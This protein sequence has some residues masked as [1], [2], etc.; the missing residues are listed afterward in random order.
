MA[1][2]DERGAFSRRGLLKAAV[3][4][5][6]ILSAA[7]LLEACGAAPARESGTS[8]SGGSAAAGTDTGKEIELLRVALPG[9][10]S[11]L[12]PGQESGILN[13][14]V[15]G[16]CMEGLVGVDTSG[17]IV[18]AL[19]SKVERTSP[20]TYV[21]T[22]RDDAKFH[23]G[24]P[25]TA[26]DILHSIEMARDAKASPSTAS[27]WA[28]LDK[29]T[30][31]G[32]NEI[33]LTSKTADEA[34]GWIPS[35]VDALWVAPKTAWE[36]AKNQLGTAQS[37]LVG[38]GPY[39]VT[40]FAPDSHVE[41][42]RVDTWHGP[43][44]KVAKIRF[45]FIADDNTR[46]LAWQANKA[47]MSLNV[48]LAQARQW[49]AAPGTR[50]VYAADRSYAG[51]TFNVTAKPF[52]DVHV[53][54]AVAHAI[55]RDAIVQKILRGRGQVATALSTPEQFGG[56]WTPEQATKEL[57]A[58]PQYAYDLE[59][60]KK[61]LAQSSVP[62]GF[63]VS[64]SY[65][66]TGPHLGTA[67]L[68]FAADLKKIGITLDVKELPIEQWL[69][70]LNT[71]PP[72]SFMWYFNTTGDPAELASWFLG[73]GNPAK[74]ANDG[75]AATMAKSGAESDPARRA[76]LL[77]EAQSAQA[78]DLAYLPLWWGQ[79]AIALSSAVGVRDYTSY[80]LL[81]NWPDH[82]YAAK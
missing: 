58:I 22:I 4:G 49:E 53:R 50:V 44:P 73:E 37:P 68:A 3:T 1:G 30:K 24:S 71:F 18:P 2:I 64:L 82:L 62:N 70:E 78:A 36:K 28:N 69:A 39:K 63:T 77:V 59:Q 40:E 60:A 29:A 14:Y 27:Y 13:Y 76:A 80:T 23:D 72:L 46:L 7:A 55:N 38:S 47:D 42:T 79:S 32:A 81:A 45:E 12:Y 25:V 33:T 20:T 16:I 57:A 67:A 17:A 74:Y 5:V 34:F 75:I 9:S 61:E 19:A 6:T 10:L 52:D 51:L 56:L 54:K 48:P 15:A 65:P 35:N 66:N 31:S 43:R 41:L 26:D 11:N 21:Y 8:G